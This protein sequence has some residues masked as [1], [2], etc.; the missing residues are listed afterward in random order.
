MTIGLATD[1]RTA[2]ME[3]LADA[4]DAT[5]NPG[6]FT[7]YS[8]DRPETTGGSLSSE[9]VELVTFTFALP[10][11]SSVANG[12]LTLDHA[13][14]ADEPA[15]ATGTATWARVFDGDGTFIMDC[16]VSRTGQGGD[17]TVNTDD[18]VQT[19]NVSV[20]GATLTDG[21]A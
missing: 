13:S 17:I 5:S 7:I 14:I 9:N 1:I 8:G 2:R 19:A 6:Y 12:V 15:L 4:I 18:F 21:S 16:D 10:C 11:A 3:I 20:T